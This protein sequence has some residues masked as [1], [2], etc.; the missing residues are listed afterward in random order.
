MEIWKHNM[1]YWNECG[2]QNHLSNAKCST[3]PYVVQN[4]FP[5]RGDRITMRYMLRKELTPLHW[6]I[7]FWKIQNTLH[8]QALTL[9]LDH[10]AMLYLNRIVIMLHYSTKGGHETSSMLSNTTVLPLSPCCEAAPSKYQ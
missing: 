4:F 8:A 7:A 2:K 6:S 5:A 1:V 10:V 3:I 9:V